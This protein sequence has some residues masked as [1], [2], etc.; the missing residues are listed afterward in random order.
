MQKPPLLTSFQ[1]GPYLLRNRVVMAPLT[2][3]RAGKD[4]V[5]TDLNALYYAQRASAGLIIA[6]AS[7]ISP[8]GVGYPSTPGIHTDAQIDGWKKV[9]ETVHQKQGL[10]FL[11]LW[12]VGRYSHPLLQKNNNLPVAPSPVKVKGRINTPLGYRDTVTPRALKINEIPGI[13]DQYVK[14]G[15]NAKKAG[16][17]GVEIHGANGYLLDQ[18]LQDGT[19]KRKDEY[20][21]SIENR[22]KLML[23]VTKSVIDSWDNGKVGLRLSPSGLKLDMFDSNPVNIFTYL[24]DKLNELNLAYLH[25]VEPLVPV[26]EYPNYLKEVTPYYRKIYKGTLITNG[27]FD[28]NK[29][30]DVIENNIAD[31]VSFGKLYIS[32]PDL[33]ERFAS[34]TSLNKW[35]KDTFYGGD[36]KG[37]TDYPYLEN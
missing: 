19:N 9:T 33:V 7:Q 17:D 28:F 27:Q 31:L 18:F 20:G 12:H 22:S 2:R 37:Y 26:D 24:I 10:I 1:L 6:E 21:E 15:E 36:E 16:F 25:L 23:E 32:N 30:N 3:R 35:D 34:N 4:N 5:P 29:G 11:Q 14:A 13:I 8:Q